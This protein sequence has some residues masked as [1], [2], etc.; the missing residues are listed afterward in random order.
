MTEPRIEI[1]VSNIVRQAETAQSPDWDAVLRAIMQPDIARQVRTR[2]VNAIINRAPSGV[3]RQLVDALLEQAARVSPRSAMLEVDPSITLVVLWAMEEGRL[4]CEDV[5]LHEF[6]LAVVRLIDIGPE[7]EEKLAECMER[8]PAGELARAEV[9]WQIISR[10]GWE[11]RTSYRFGHMLRSDMPT[12]GQVE[13]LAD[14]IDGQWGRIGYVSGALAASGHPASIDFVQRMISSVHARLGTASGDDLIIAQRLKVNL[15]QS[16]AMAHAV[17]LPPMDG[18]RW[19]A[20]T[21][22]A[23]PSHIR[24]WV[25]VQALERGCP[26]EEARSV[27]FAWRKDI[28]ARCE[29]LYR[30]LEKPPRDKRLG[31]DLAVT[32]ELGRVQKAA[33]NL[34]IVAHD[35]LA[36]ESPVRLLK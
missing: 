25:A 1:D 36:K 4:S 27:L 30:T 35:E 28:E 15:D 12:N 3:Q 16:L 20:D 22:R 17:T 18:L 32:S 21:T 23:F 26:R 29:E 13:A 7:A 34:G 19:A 33:E 11:V 24:E 31:L 10:R 6:R 5:Q 8:R 14:T 2:L 9:A